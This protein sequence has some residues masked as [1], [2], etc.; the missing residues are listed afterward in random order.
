MVVLEMLWV[1]GREV[2]LYATPRR[3]VSPRE[4]VSSRPDLMTW[5][6]P[7][8]KRLID[9]LVLVRISEWA[10]VGCAL[11]LQINQQCLYGQP[12][13]AHDHQLKFDESD[14]GGNERGHFELMFTVVG[15]FSGYHH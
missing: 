8:K 6:K 2:R 5:I 3:L 10:F 14:A 13:R 12:Q 4:G 7:Q 15:G 11:L 1:L 9:I